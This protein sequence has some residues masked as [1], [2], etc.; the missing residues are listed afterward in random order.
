LTTQP[1]P[2]PPSPIIFINNKNNG[3]RG[4]F[5]FLPINTS[6]LTPKLYKIKRGGIFIGRQAKYG[7]CQEVFG[8]IIMCSFE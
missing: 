1:P 2:P 6:I 3:V 5:L 4:Y 8:V 7:N